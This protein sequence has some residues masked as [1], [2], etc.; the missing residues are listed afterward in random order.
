MLKKKKEY[1][2]KVLF[3]HFTFSIFTNYCS[4]VIRKIETIIDVT[5]TR[6]AN[7]K[8]KK[9][10]THTQTNKLLNQLMKSTFFLDL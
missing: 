6:V 8:S 3:I 2:S 10:T 1:K 5:Y 7:K 4:K 9:E